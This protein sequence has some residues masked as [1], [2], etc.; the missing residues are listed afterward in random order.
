MMEENKNVGDQHICK[1]CDKEFKA[2]KNL[3]E[4]LNLVHNRKRDKKCDV[5]SKTF[6]LRKTL[7]HHIKRVHEGQKNFQC[8]SCMYEIILS[9]K[10]P[11][12]TCSIRP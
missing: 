9:R 5:C 7:L 2:R 8:S 12:E 4:H 6:K 1:V 11:E 10:T 3:V